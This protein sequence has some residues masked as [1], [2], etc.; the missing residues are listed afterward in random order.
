MS[1]QETNVQDSLL[2]TQYD[3]LALRKQGQCVLHCLTQ[4]LN[5][6]Q[7]LQ[8]VKGEQTYI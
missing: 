3:P 6:Q 7:N 4:Y 5:E 2:P 1:F 8:R